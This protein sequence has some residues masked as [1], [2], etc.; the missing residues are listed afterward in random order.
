MDDPEEGNRLKKDSINSNYTFR[1]EDINFEHKKG[2]SY[3]HTGDDKLEEKATDSATRFDYKSNY[4]RNMGSEP[5]NLVQSKF[6]EEKELPQ[7][8]ENS[9]I[10]NS[11]LKSMEL[12]VLGE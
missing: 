3:S 11:E 8:E 7:D 6:E 5:S 2:E 12:N 10:T 4:D 1:D 9:M